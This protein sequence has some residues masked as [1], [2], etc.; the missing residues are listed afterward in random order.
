MLPSSARCVAVAALALNFGLGCGAEDVS[1][2]DGLATPPELA[3]DPGPSGAV[4]VPVQPSARF[5][6]ITAWAGLQ[7]SVPGQGAT[8]SDIDG[9]G[10]DDVILPGRERTILLRNRGDGS[11]YPIQVLD[12]PDE[13]A[14][15]AYTI[16]ATG[17]SI[18]DVLLVR[19]RGPVLY[20]GY[21]NGGLKPLGGLLPPG[22]DPPPSASV[23]TFGDWDEDGRLDL[24][25]GYITAYET[26]EGNPFGPGG[27]CRERPPEGEGGRSLED[28]PSVDRLLLTQLG[29]FV[30]A[31][32]S[33]GVGEA[34]YTQAAMTVDI[35]ADG[36]L[37]LL[38]GTEGLRLD[39][40]YYGAGT[41][42][43]QERGVA[44]GMD[45]VTSAMGYD[46][47]DIDEDG[48]L[49]LYVTDD[50][51]L[52]GDKL[53]LQQS[54]GTF[55][56]ATMDRGLKITNEYTGWGIGWH[57]LDLDGDLDLF[58]VNGKP[59]GD[60]CGGGEQLNLLFENDGSGHFEHVPSPGQPSGLE[61]LFNS[62]AASFSDIDGDGDLDVLISN[63]DAPP[64][65]LRN[66]MGDSRHWL[67]VR[68]RHP[69]LS[70]PVGARIT[71]QVEGRTLR[72]DVKGTPSY[73]GSSTDTVHFGL[74]DAQKATALTVVW[75]DGTEQAVGDVDADQVLVVSPLAG[76]S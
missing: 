8:F 25:L 20:R 62:R 33:A 46:A 60:G 41:G 14:L 6:D 63:I 43:F 67:Q 28:P 74:G 65:L 23:A 35:D 45:R 61:A 75:P 19:E 34:L 3:V 68:L 2:D 16:D 44:L 69:G 51:L 26:D 72:R 29:G 7:L 48:D 37:D 49:D 52:D 54:D 50:T 24:Y 18:S 32:E 76:G 21:E 57:D 66:D 10:I 64:T 1:V 15:F 5:S 73:G 58:V 47:V 59:L 53:Y 55:Q 39:H 9:D 22:P 42:Q 56:Y 38:I 13:D 11:F 36:H 71:L 40:A 12:H 27:D 4:P 70:P 30:D 17:D 31:A